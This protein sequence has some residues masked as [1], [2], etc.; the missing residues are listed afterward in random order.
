MS[1]CRPVETGVRPFANYFRILPPID[2]PMRSIIPGSQIE[3]LALAGIVGAAALFGVAVDTTIEGAKMLWGVDPVLVTRT[4]LPDSRYTTALIFTSSSAMMIA[5]AMGALA[6]RFGLPKTALFTSAC[7]LGTVAAHL[8]AATAAW[9]TTVEPCFAASSAEVTSINTMLSAVVSM[10]VT[11]LMYPA[12]LMWG[13]RE[14]R[15]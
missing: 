7:A 13:A 3:W 5:G 12:G 11:A 14:R 6:S 15:I 1:S 8:S 10:V 4:W 2:V 9:G